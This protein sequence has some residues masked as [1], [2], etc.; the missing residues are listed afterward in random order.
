MSLC[1]TWIFSPAVLPSN[2]WYL[3]IKH[4]NSSFC[5]FCVWLTVSLGIRR[6]L[7]NFKDFILSSSLLFTSF[8]FLLRERDGK[9]CLNKAFRKPSEHHPRTF[10]CSLDML[11]ALWSRALQI[12][13]F[14]QSGNFT[15]SEV[16]VA[17][18]Y[19]YLLQLN[20]GFFKMIHKCFIIHKY[21]LISFRFC[22]WWWLLTAR[23]SW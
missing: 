23:I 2:I 3:Q 13:I 4:V 16:H 14:I 1:Y 22:K 17:V 21:I 9:V 5:I 19:K 11:S 10:V 20:T 15:W 7:K 8:S 12:S 6:A 18:H